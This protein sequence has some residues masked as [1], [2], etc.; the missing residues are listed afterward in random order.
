MPDCG[1]KLICEQFDIVHNLPL[2]PGVQNAGFVIKIQSASDHLKTL[3]LC[4]S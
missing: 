3:N 4:V 1:M 2:S